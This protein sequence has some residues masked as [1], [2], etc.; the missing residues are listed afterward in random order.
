MSTGRCHPR[1]STDSPRLWLNEIPP[2]SPRLPEPHSSAATS[3]GDKSH[4]RKLQRCVLKMV[5]CGLS[6]SKPL[7]TSAIRCPCF[8]HRLFIGQAVSPQLKGLTKEG[9]VHDFRQ[10]IRQLR[11]G[12]HPSDADAFTCEVTD[13]PCV[14]LR[15]EFRTIGRC[16]F[17]KKIVERATIRGRHIWLGP[18]GGSGEGL[19]QLGQCRLGISPGRSVV[20]D[21]RPIQLDPRNLVHR[22]THRHRLCR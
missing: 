19:W 13:C 17:G 9:V 3:S 16:R 1:S 22:G 12:V 4:S 11:T 6:L 2:A 20:Q 15:S 18:V 5:L 21:P 14:K 10:P 8:E 7:E